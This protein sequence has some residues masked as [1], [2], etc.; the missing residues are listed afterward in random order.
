MLISGW[1][2]DPSHATS[3]RASQLFL[4]EKTLECLSQNRQELQGFAEAAAAVKSGRCD[5]TKTGGAAA[6]MIAEKEIGIVYRFNDLLHIAGRK[7]L[8]QRRRK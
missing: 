4:L 6:V 1:P 7:F 5:C 8:C 3:D 2:R